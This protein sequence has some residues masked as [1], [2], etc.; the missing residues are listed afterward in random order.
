MLYPIERNDKYGFINDKNEIII[1]PQFD[2]IGNFSNEVCNV[3]NVI[4]EIHFEMDNKKY[5]HVES[6]IIDSNGKML[7][8]FSKYLVIN[9]FYDEVAFCYNPILKK[10]GVI[11]KKGKEL[12]PFIFDTSEIEYSKFSNGLAK[13]KK[14]DKYG[15]INKN[16]ELVIPCIYD[17][18][19]HFNEDFALAKI[20]SKEFLINKNG[21]IFKSKYKIVSTFNDGFAKVKQNKMFGFI[22]KENNLIIDFIFDSIWNNFK[23]EHCLVSLNKKYGLI[24]K[25]GNIIIDFQFTDVRSIGNNV[26]PA[27]IKN[28]WTLVNLNGNYQFEPKFDYIDDFDKVQYELDYKNSKLT[29]AVYKN[30]DYYIDSFGNTIREIKTIEKKFEENE[31]QNILTH[32]IERNEVWD[33]AIWS[34]DGFTITKKGAIRPYYFLLNWF[35][36]KNLL[37]NSGIEALHDKNNLEIGLYRFM[38]QEKAA[39]FL[40]YFYKYWYEKQHIANYQLDPDL[41][42]EGDENL[43]KYW[44]LYNKNYG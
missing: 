33:K 38:F 32:K 12:I 43:E 31:I 36:K 20:K 16:N 26:F 22:N 19:S 9:N 27:K 18:A 4:D 6:S 34:Y 17:N 15:F 37:T 40:D 44:E 39:V 11:D 1:K 7:F 35:A 25:S 24:N 8:P 14:N 10:H 3:A 30:K 21:E 13:I 28:K 41:K 42:F 2:Y 5:F 23:E 29:R